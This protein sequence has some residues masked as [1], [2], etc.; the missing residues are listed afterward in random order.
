MLTR[1]DVAVVDDHLLVAEALQALLNARGLQAGSVPP[2]PAVELVSVLQ[3][4]APR[5]VLLDLDL[6]AW[7]SS[8]GL[9]RPLRD[10]G[11][12]VLLMTGVTRPLRIAEAL[13]QGA[14][15]YQAKGTDFAALLDRVSA[16]LAAVTTAE[17]A[18][19]PAQPLDPGG[20]AA[21]LAE[22]TASRTERRHR[23]A[24]FQKLT[25]RE[26]DALRALCQGRSVRQIAADWVVSEATVR[27]HVRG[28]LTKLDVPTQLAA[29]A[30]ATAGG[31]LTAAGGRL[32]K[33][34]G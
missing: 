2:A 1:L 31:W 23:L 11:I 12:S 28:I 21:L 32:A 6:G 15:G 22:L 34:S 8:L 24:P 27:S 19:R 30:R 14:I 5:L 26:A 10:C 18:G 4:R 7:G 13:E 16:A 33:S 20:R 9:I 17:E 25:E 3:L 29:V